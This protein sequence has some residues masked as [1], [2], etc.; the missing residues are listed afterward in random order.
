MLHQMPFVLHIDAVRALSGVGVK[1]QHHGRAADRADLITERGIIDIAAGGEHRGLR[2][3]VRTVLFEKSP[4][5]QRVQIA[6]LVGTV[7]L[8]PERGF[9]LGG[10]L[11][12]AVKQQFA[13]IVRAVIKRS[14]P[15]EQRNLAGKRPRAV[16]PAQRGKA[17][18]LQLALVELRAG[19]CRDAIDRNRRAHGAN[20]RADQPGGVGYLK[21]LVGIAASQR[22]AVGVAQNAVDIAKAVDLVGAVM[23]RRGVAVDVVDAKVVVLE[24]ARHKPRGQ[25]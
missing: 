2:I 8:Q 1:R 17:E 20:L 10:G 12:D 14:D 11:G 7:E 15:A 21:M 19:K 22:D 24:I 5:A 18:G 16:Q 4:E 6:Q 23:D 3:A 13:R 9:A 25:A